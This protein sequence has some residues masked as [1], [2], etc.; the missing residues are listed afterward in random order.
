MFL[1]FRFSSM[2]LTAMFSVIFSRYTLYGIFLM[3]PNGVFKQFVHVQLRI[4]S[5]ML[6]ALVLEFRCSSFVLAKLNVTKSNEMNFASANWLSAQRRYRKFSIYLIWNNNLHF[7]HFLMQNSIF[8][9][10]TEWRSRRFYPTKLK[11]KGE[12]CIL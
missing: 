7:E 6:I 8:A 10:N 4:K 3:C 5:S 9:W 1:L 2:V 12:K 11:R